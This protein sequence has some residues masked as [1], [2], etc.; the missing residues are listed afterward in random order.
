MI[1]SASSCHRTLFFFLSG[2][3]CLL[4]ACEYFVRIPLHS[5]MDALSSLAVQICLTDLVFCTQMRCF[6]FFLKKKK[7]DLSNFEHMRHST[8]IIKVLCSFTLGS[9]VKDS[10][11]NTDVKDCL[12]PSQCTSITAHRFPFWITLLQT[13]LWHILLSHWEFYSLVRKV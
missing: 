7:T 3:L 10:F 6:A 4:L 12:F 8:N 11:I 1:S 13:A 5:Q 2:H 9:P